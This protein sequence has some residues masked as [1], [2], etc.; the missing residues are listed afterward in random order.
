MRGYR[1]RL[2]LYLERWSPGERDEVRS[3]LNAMARELVSEL[4]VVPATTTA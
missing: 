2:A 1:E 3:M 4:P